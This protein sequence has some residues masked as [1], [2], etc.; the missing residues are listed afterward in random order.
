MGALKESKCF[1][2]SFSSPVSSKRFWHSQHLKAC[3][4]VAL[5][6]SL[7]AIHALM[8]PVEGG[9]AL[10]SSHWYLWYQ[11]M[12][13]AIKDKP[14]LK[15]ISWHRC[16]VEMFIYGNHVQNVLHQ[17]L[18]M[19]FINIYIYTGLNLYSDTASEYI[20][21]YIFRLLIFMLQ[22]CNEAF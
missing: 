22:Y 8:G 4:A 2:S 11:I 3:M 14:G 20:L 21:Y 1:F 18:N 7:L 5:T 6:A 12:V 17:C 9:G 10:L 13:Q 15:A 16:F 19:Q